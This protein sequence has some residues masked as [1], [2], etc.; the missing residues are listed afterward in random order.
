MRRV[1]CRG[2]NKALLAVAGLLIMMSAAS[3]GAQGDMR[4][5]IDK[6]GK[7]VVFAGPGGGNG[8]T[9]KSLFADFTKDTGI[10]VDYLAGPV[11]D[12]YGRI[13]VERNQPTIDVYYSSPVT[14]VKGIE[15][16]IYQPLDPGI[17]PNIAQLYDMARLP[18]NLGVRFTLTAMGILYNKK[19]YQQNNIPFPQTWDDLWNPKAGGHIILGDTSSFY[20]VMYIAYL[21]KRLGG[22]EADPT[23]GIKYI[24]DQKDKLLAIVRTYPQRVQFLATGQAWA[25]VDGGGSSLPE[26]H[27]NADLGF[28]SPAQGAPL[29][30]QGLHVVKG[31]RNPI[32]AQ[33][34]INYLISEPVQRRLAMES[35]IGPVNKTVKLDD[36]FARLVPYGPDA[37]A[38]LT[39]LDSVAISNALDKYRTEWDARVSAK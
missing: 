3:A 11:Q 9:L 14:E 37:V 12:L 16:G 29:Y 39:V 34:L 31:A 35:Y 24:A 30:F 38:K 15:E 1:G 8:E 20:T 7:S 6:A 5:L 23:P 13:K 18:N 4:A 21:T 10:R 27:K 2:M 22:T 26:V 36:N 25:T 28:V 17:V 19:A 33:L 32:G